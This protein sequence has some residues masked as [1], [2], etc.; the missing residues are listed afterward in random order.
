MDNA[1]KI[2]NIRGTGYL[3]KTNLPS[4]TAFRGFGG[5]QAMMVVEAWMSDIAEVC[6]LP[7]E[8]VCRMKLFYAGQMVILRAGRFQKKS[9]GLFKLLSK[10]TCVLPLSK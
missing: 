2:P 5:P 3:C 8:H 1:Y 4:N 10:A 7:P 9:C 6:K